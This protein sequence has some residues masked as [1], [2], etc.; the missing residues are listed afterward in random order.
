[1]SSYIE[2]NLRLDAL[3]NHLNRFRVLRVHPEDPSAAAQL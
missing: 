3:E 2:S 1:M